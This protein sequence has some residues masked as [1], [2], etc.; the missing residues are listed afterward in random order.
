MSILNWIIETWCMPW[1]T[2]SYRHRS[3]EYDRLLTSI[4]SKGIRPDSISPVRLTATFGDSVIWLGNYPYGF[5]GLYNDKRTNAPLPTSRVAYRFNQY[6]SRL[7]L[8]EDLK[9]LYK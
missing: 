1:A 2:P 8:E 9:D 4:M 7:I 3:A 6:M 5:G